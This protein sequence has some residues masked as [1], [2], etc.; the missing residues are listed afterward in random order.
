MGRG[1]KYLPANYSLPSQFPFRREKESEKDAADVCVLQLLSFSLS[2]TF[3]ELSIAIA[4]EDEKKEHTH[5]CTAQHNCE[6]PDTHTQT[7][8]SIDLLW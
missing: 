1:G 2:F 8:H 3:T 7:D 5:L 4:V 6:L